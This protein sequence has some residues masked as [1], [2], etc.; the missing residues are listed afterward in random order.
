MTAEPNVAECPE[1]QPADQSAA[2]AAQAL[3]QQATGF[4]LSQA[5]WVAAKLSVADHLRDG[6]MAVEKLASITGCHPPALYR[7]LRAL[8]A[9]QVFKEV[10]RGTFELAPRGV[11]LCA[12]AED[13]IRDL[14]LLFV[15]E[16]FWQTWG[17]LLH[18]VRTGETAFPHLFGVRNSFEHYARNPEESK[19]MNDAMTA[20]SLAIASAVVAACDFSGARTI[21]DIGGGHGTLISS[22]LNTNPNLRGILFDFER[23]VTGAVDVL[24][25]AGVA[26]R[27]DVVAGD[28]FVSVPAGCDIYLLSRVINICDDAQAVAV[29]KNCRAAMASNAKV[30]LVERVL[31]E[32]A[33]P[34]SM[35]QS[36]AMSDLTMLLRT[37]GRERTGVE[38]HAL[39]IEAGL[40]ATRIVPTASPVSVIEA[41]RT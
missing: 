31:P 23:V 28:M 25:K 14:V 37:G 11:C 24:D 20:G 35:T 18:S 10:E 7:L 8:A 33:E 40:R 16:N 34:T 9:F 15:G 4:Q 2:T 21:A 17:A 13:S 41:V 22:A 5:I 26:A 30:I 12:D 29:L 39:L 38:F 36:K 27:C 1:G 32:I 19:L 3:L 6:R